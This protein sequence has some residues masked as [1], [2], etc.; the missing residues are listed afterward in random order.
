MNEM[1]KIVQDFSDPAMVL[2]VQYLWHLRGS[3]GT[4]DRWTVWSKA[5]NHAL[6]TWDTH[7]ASRDG[8]WEKL[9]PA[10]HQHIRFL[11]DRK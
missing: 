11:T 2:W 5:W 3:M 7:H 4:I 10:K 9:S 8:L 1:K 6:G